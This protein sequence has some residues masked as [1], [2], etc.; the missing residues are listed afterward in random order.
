MIPPLIV[1]K[2]ADDRH[3][4]ISLSL[5]DSLHVE[6]NVV[7]NSKYLFRN[8]EWRSDGLE[9]QSMNYIFRRVSSR[10]APKT[11]TST[12]CKTNC[13]LNV[14]WHQPIYI[15]TMTYPGVILP[16]TYVRVFRGDD[17]AENW[18]FKKPALYVAS[19]QVAS[20]AKI[21]IHILRGYVESAIQKKE[22]CP[23][24]LEALV[25]GHI[26]MT[27]CGHL[28]ER[29]ALVNMLKSSNKCPTC[30]CEIQDDFINL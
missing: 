23:I 13:Y 26:S 2:A 10:S 29:Q 4:L 17:I 11:Y 6:A 14:S 15:Y 1:L 24:T 18:H 7:E 9:G 22:V 20:P 5:H 19:P 28:F 16:S 8:A 25:M 27:S 3:V 21:P 12:L 30:R